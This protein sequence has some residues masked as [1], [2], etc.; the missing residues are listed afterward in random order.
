MGI[1]SETIA[2]HLAANDS[3]ISLVYRTLD[4]LVEQ[5]ELDDAAVV[6]DEPGLGRQ[7]FRAGRKPLDTERRGAARRAARPLHRA[8]A[9]AS[10]SSTGR[11]CSRCARSRCG[12]T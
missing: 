3:G 12:S 5:Y 6:L 2:A 4:A 7:V 9:R 11:S 1:L 10:P 8:A